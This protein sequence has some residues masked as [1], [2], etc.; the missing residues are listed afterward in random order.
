MTMRGKAGRGLARLL[1]GLAIV[2]FAVFSVLSSVN[3]TGLLGGELPDV[4]RVD[5]GV[6]DKTE[7]SATGETLRNNGFSPKSVVQDEDL[8]AFLDEQERHAGIANP[9]PY[10]IFNS[11]VTQAAKPGDPNVVPDVLVDGANNTIVGLYQTYSNQRGLVCYTSGDPREL[12]AQWVN[13]S[14]A[15]KDTSMPMKV[16]VTPADVAELPAVLNPT[17]CYVFPS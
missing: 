3:L 5:Q 4:P 13:I 6:M 10:V 11:S 16:E 8:V 7:A 17:H 9:G 15:L 14:V 1:L 12:S 2:A